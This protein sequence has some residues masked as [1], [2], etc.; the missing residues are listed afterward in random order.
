MSFMVDQGG[1]VFQKDLGADTEK[2]AATMTT[3]KK[4]PRRCG[5]FFYRGRA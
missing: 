2:L 5:A 3:L 4:R 1:V